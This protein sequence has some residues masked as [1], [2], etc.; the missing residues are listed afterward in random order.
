MPDLEE[1]HPLMTLA[2]N[3]G[4]LSEV[5]LVAIIKLLT[6]RG[7]TIKKM[8]NVQLFFTELHKK[9]SDA[10]IKVMSIVFL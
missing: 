10:T 8:T 9:L 2:F 7:S 4:S 1:N 5:Q 6:S 3:C